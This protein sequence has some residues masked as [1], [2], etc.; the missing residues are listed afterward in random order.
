MP[1]A[2]PGSGEVA[3]QIPVPPA[4][5]EMRGAWEKEL[6][7]QQQP[8]AP[9]LSSCLL[10]PAPRSRKVPFIDGCCSSPSCFFASLSGSSLLCLFLQCYGLLLSPKARLP[11]HSHVLDG[12]RQGIGEAF[13]FLPCLSA[14][15]AEKGNC[16]ALG[17]LLLGTED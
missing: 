14:V 7:H 2:T 3:H 13:G 1:T 6:T 15:W 12:G 16:T 17:W 11:V 8:G 4:P 5:R 9:L 10:P